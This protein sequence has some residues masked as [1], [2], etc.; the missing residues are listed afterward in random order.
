VPPHRR[1]GR[2]PKD[3]PRTRRAIQALADHPGVTSHFDLTDIGTNTHAQIDTH[4]ADTTIHFTQAQIDHTGILNIGTNSHIQLDAHLAASSG[5]HGITGSVVGTTDAQT[6]SNKTLTTP[7]IGSFVNATH[8]HSNAAGGGTISHTVLTNIGTNTH[9]QIDTHISSSSGVHGVVG[10]VVGTTDTQTLSNKT[11]TTPTISSFAN[12]THDHSN[13]AGGGTVSHTVLSNIG[14]NT[15]AQIDS[16]IAATAAHGATGA[17]VGTT[18]TQTLTNKTLTT[19][20]I[21]DFSNANHNHSNAAGGGTISHANLTGIGTNTHAQIDTH[22]AA[23]SGV[24]GI[25]GSV[26]GTTDTQTLTNKTLTTPTIGSFANAGHDHTNAAGGGQLTDAALSAA[27]GVAKGGTGLSSV[28]SKALLKGDGTSPLVEI[29]L[30]TA[31][32]AL[33]VNSAGTDWIATTIIQG[34]T[35]TVNY[36]GVANVTGTP[37]NT[38]GRFIRVGSQVFFFFAVTVNATAT[39]TTTTFTA[40]I[41]VGGNFG[42][43][44]QAVALALSND[45]I[46][47]VSISGAA[48]TV[49]AATLTISFTSKLAGN[50]PLMVMGMYIPQ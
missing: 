48:A 19:P 12:A 44:N 36:A 9:A 33:Q 4:I 41:P 39:A 11:L 28:T 30:G 5:V 8:N 37:S 20:T 7:T 25:T 43:T 42:A 46:G 23:A 47:V 31:L 22:I 45:N 29:A 50:H 34:S 40:T 38:T 17:V 3:D 16:H 15:H 18:N 14:T 6:L 24:H 13:A 21:G 35:W 1:P 2:T 26:V 10:A 32:A 49:G 27:V